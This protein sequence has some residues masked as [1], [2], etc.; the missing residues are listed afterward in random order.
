[1]NKITKGAL[2]AGAAVALLIGTGTTLAYWNSTVNVGEPTVISAGDLRLAQTSAP[3]WTIAHTDGTETVVAD[4]TSVRIVPG[5]RLVFGAEYQIAAQGRNLDISAVITEGSIAPVNPADT[6]DV[7]LAS[8]LVKSAAFTI[9]GVAGST[10]TI[11]HRSDTTGT[12]NVVIDVTLDW[13]FGADGSQTDD[14]QAKTGQV[15]LSQFA[16]S[17][18]QVDVV[19]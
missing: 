12:Y 7:S 11:Q 18:N 13:S 10:A 15:N 1:M 6:A 14:N 5:D 19:A 9:N 17:V 3:T 8:N 4:L 16:V 2:A